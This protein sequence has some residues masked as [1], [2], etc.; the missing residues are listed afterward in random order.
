MK[1]VENRCFV[2]FL[3]DFSGFNLFL[4][5]KINQICRFWSSLEGELTNFTFSDE[6]ERKW[7]EQ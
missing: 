4:T 2:S 3:V 6:N 1:R 5:K 7:A